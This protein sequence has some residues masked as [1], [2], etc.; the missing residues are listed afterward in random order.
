[1]VNKSILDIKNVRVIEFSSLLVDLANRL[2]INI[3][4][5]GLRGVNDFGV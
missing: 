3:V 2:D 5:R 1:M 4:V